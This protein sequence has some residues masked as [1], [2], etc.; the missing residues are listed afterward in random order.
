M[1][2]YFLINKSSLLIIVFIQKQFG[3]INQKLVLFLQVYIEPHI[4]TKRKNCAL[5]W[6]ILH[7]TLYFPDI[8][9]KRLSP[10]YFKKYKISK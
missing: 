7:H 6:K 4:E 1:E 3:L 9:T 2:I 8:F 5:G 10:R